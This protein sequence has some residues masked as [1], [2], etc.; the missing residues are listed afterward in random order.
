[1]DGIQRSA[2]DDHIQRCALQA[3]ENGKGRVRHLLSHARYTTYEYRLRTY[4][5]FIDGKTH[6]GAVLIACRGR[7]DEV[8]RHEAVCHEAMPLL[9][10]VMQEC[11][12]HAPSPPERCGARRRDLV[13]VY[14]STTSWVMLT[15]K[16]I[17][18]VWF[19]SFKPA[20][21]AFVVVVPEDISSQSAR[22]TANSINIPTRLLS[23]RKSSENF[24]PVLLR[25]LQPSYRWTDKDKYYVLSVVSLQ[26][27]FLF[28]RVLNAVTSEAEPLLF[29]LV[30]RECSFVFE[31][32]TLAEE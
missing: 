24:S 4:E 19:D 13:M 21:K 25:T 5:V 1:M 31:E 2:T 22:V 6:D 26:V 12:M 15:F 17:P 14:S 27:Q 18:R 32:V 23:V 28:K 11:A 29:R 20:R 9:R 10:G 30:R 3:G 7:A 8:D 16:E